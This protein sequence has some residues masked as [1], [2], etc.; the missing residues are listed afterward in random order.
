MLQ[1][2][3]QDI[4]FFFFFTMEGD[5]S[6]NY[7]D[8]H[9]EHI[10][11]PVTQIIN[12]SIKIVHQASCDWWFSASAKAHRI[13]VRKSNFKNVANNLFLQSRATSEALQY[14]I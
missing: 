4:F 8:Y 10:V 13:F 7:M 1:T 5:I 2:V 3:S 6:G 12:L 11:M 14:G 9:L